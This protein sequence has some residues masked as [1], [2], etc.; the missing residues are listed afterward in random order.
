MS[1][2]AALDEERLD[3]LELLQGLSN[4]PSRQP[5]VPGSPVGPG[6][7][8]L[9]RSSSPYNA[10]RSPVR[11]MLDVVEDPRPRNS[12]IAGTSSSGVT[13]IRSMLDI[14]P[15][16]PQISKSASTSP[17]DSFPSLSLLPKPLSEIPPHQPQG[18]YKGDV[19]DS[20]QFSGYLHSNP[21]APLAP[22]RNTL[23]GK[24][25]VPAPLP[26]G[27]RV[28][29]P[30]Y[31]A[32]DKVHAMCTTGIGSSNKSKSPHNRHSLRSSSPALGPPPTSNML[33]MD[34]GAVVDKDSAYRRLSDA[35]LARAGGSFSALTTKARR[36]TDS[37][38]KRDQRLQKDYT[39]TG[40]EDV[41][42]SSDEA[43]TGEDGPRGRRSEKRT[44]KVDDHPESKTVAEEER[45]MME[46]KQQ[47]KV[48][49]LL[50][51]EITIT[52]P[53]GDRLKGAAKPGVH[54]TNAFDHEGGSGLSTPHDS[55][56]EQEISDIRRAQRLAINLTPIISTPE[57]QR[58]VRTLFRGDFNQMQKEAEYQRRVR[59]YLVAT[60]LSEE[61][62]HAL[63]WTVGTVLRD[64]DTLLAIY[65]VDE[66]TGIIPDTNIGSD[67]TATIE[68]QA[69]SIASATHAI[70]PPSISSYSTMSSHSHIP[71]PLGTPRTDVSA[72]PMSRDRPRTE[73]ER[74]RAIEDI[75]ERVSKL[76]RKTK[77]QV[78]V[79]IEVIHCKSPKHLICEVIDYFNP[80]LVI[81]GSRG[82]SALKGVILGSFSN[83]L[84]T[85]SSVPVMVARKR[86]RKHTK[87]KRSSVRLANNLTGVSGKTLASA[88]ID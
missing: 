52:G 47:Y 80:T 64:G 30:G 15:P 67:D 23:A 66:E 60:D 79:V 59:K 19:T 82:R 42:E 61:A 46:N 88:K 4:K 16:A 29:L 13:P 55:D 44:S 26:E 84:V 43:S 57:T 86:L 78:R 50:E 2:E 1:M 34:S 20:Y 81:L 27:V 74:H 48:R 75:T 5:R 32:R 68:K 8:L 72:S 45:Q 10:H 21:G 12:S 40:A 76:L 35:N 6:P 14:G 31:S 53:G 37:N 77:L 62:A 54:P 22:K 25:A 83:Y 28:D 9:G 11:S 65:C 18:R 7:A 63:E 3:V 38:D 56:T 39:F 51:P 41:V 69:A 58:S 71:S 49:S 85:K 17:T 36:R 24:K 70:P 73:Q 87:Y 33:V